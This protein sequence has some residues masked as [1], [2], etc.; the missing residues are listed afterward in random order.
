MNYINIVYVLGIIGVINTIYLSYH[1]LTKKPVWCLFFPEEWCK[2]VQYSSWSRTFGIPKTF[3]GLGIYS[4]LIV[5]T[6]LFSSGSISFA[7]VQYLIYFGFAFSMYFL[8]IQAF[9]LRAF[10]TWCVLSAI[11]FTLLLLVTIYL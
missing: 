1:T 5:L 10:C 3:A 7:P 6:Y 8:G 11:D 9:V 4:L 2:K